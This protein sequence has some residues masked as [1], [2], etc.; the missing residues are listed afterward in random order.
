MSPAPVKHASAA[1]DGLDRGGPGAAGVDAGAVEAFLDD[2]EAA[3]LELHSLMLHRH[4]RVVAEGWR[5]PYGP[6]RLRVMHSYAKSVTAC[7]IGL[8]IAEGHF[9]LSDKVVSFFPDKLPAV[10]SDNLAAMTVEDLLTM[11][12]GHDGETG[13]PTWRGIKTSWITEFFKIPVVHQP[14]T[15][16]VY[17]SA[18]SYMLGAILAKTTRQTLHEYLKPRLFEPLG[19]EGETWDIG[20]DGFNPGGNGLTC[21]VSDALKVGI[22]HAQNG[23]WQGRQL[24][25]ASWIAQATQT[26]AGGRYGYHWV[27]NWGG[28]YCAL[29]MFVQMVMVFPAQG[30]TLAL[31]GAIDGSQL[32]MPFLEK[33]FP[34][35]FH[36][37]PLHNDAADA[38]LQARLATWRDVPALASAA[39][40][41]ARHSDKPYRVA[42]NPLGVRDLRFDFT[43]DRCVFHLTDSD[44]THTVTAGLGAWIEGH[45][46]MPGRDLHHGYHLRGATV[47]ASAVWKDASTLEMTWIFAET[48]F[49]D[50]V[51]CRFNGSQ[52]TLERRVNVNSAARAH[53]PLLGTL[54]TA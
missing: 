14:G 40:D 46:D 15:T 24:I 31:T 43:A 10:V 6:A 30:A 4:G 35:T 38:R 53:P 42:D 54:A 22:L 49:R 7:A 50:T 17:T 3:G 34:R 47:V 28:A 23:L 44:G 26:H 8:A 39:V 1:A 52:V 36:T 13:G 18:A 29:G 32:V 12:T 9:G 45:T 16:Y 33:H 27:T 21:R 41:T 25:P 37:G 2:V 5:W 51:L 20:P 48:A 19:F 11:R